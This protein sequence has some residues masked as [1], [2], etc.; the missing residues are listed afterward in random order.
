MKRLLAVRQIA[1]SPIGVSVVPYVDGPDPGG[2]LRRP[3]IVG[4]NHDRA[5]D[6]LGHLVEVVYEDFLAA[7]VVDVLVL[8]VGDTSP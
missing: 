5:V 6:P 7:E 3:R 1:D 4:T 2:D 8:D